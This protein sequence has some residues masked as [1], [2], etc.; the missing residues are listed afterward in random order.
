MKN[1]LHHLFIPSARNN[2]R[3]KLLHLDALT[4]CLIALI[5]T[6][7]IQKTTPL[8]DVLG[9]ATDISAARLTE[10][11][12]E[13]RTA[14]GLE[15]L[16]HDTTLD[17]A[18]CDKAQ[19]M[20]ADQCWAHFCPNGASPWD[21]ITQSGYRYL[22]AGENLCKNFMTSEG[23]FNGWMQSATHRE[24]ILRT[25]Y[26]DIGFC[27]LNGSIQGEDT[28]LVVQM[29]GTP[30]NDGNFAFMRTVGAEEQ[31]SDNVIPTQTQT[32]QSAGAITPSPSGLVSAETR[33][34]TDIFTN[35]PISLAHIFLMLLIFTLIL[36]F[37]YAYKLQVVRFTGKHTLHLVFLIIIGLSIIILQKGAI[38]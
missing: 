29:F 35:L 38:L 27:V 8:G 25:V 1:L 3:S 21:S 26:R 7:F 23:C 36:D 18:A 13:A 16:N 31:N 24:N 4:L 10:L 20:F 9:I 30:L 15:V 2:Y 17:V 11:T 6:S 32:V 14:N 34:K 19:K 22:Y 33:S 28:T 37:Y 12:N 5:T